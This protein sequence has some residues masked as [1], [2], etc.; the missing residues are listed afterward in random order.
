[1][2]RS[3]LIGGDILPIRIIIAKRHSP[4]DGSED[5]SLY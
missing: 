5:T 3:R 1:L 2:E 4:A